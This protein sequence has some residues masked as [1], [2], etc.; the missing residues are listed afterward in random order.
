S[1]GQD[2]SGYGVYAQRYDASGNPVGAEFR[3]NTFATGNQEES[4][5]TSL[6]DGGFVVQWMS[7]G[8]D[9]SGWGTYAQRYDASGNPLSS[10][11]LVNQ[12]TTGDQ[13]PDSFHG[14]TAI[15]QLANGNLISVW[16]GLPSPNNTFEIHA[17]EF[18]LGNPGAV[19]GVRA[20]AGDPTTAVTNGVDA[21]I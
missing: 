20:E 1:N 17:R 4:S 7:L 6:A 18:T 15:A 21:A 14:M 12:T 8:Q 2:G 11:F 5:I 3:V 9:G 10:E 19:I 16:E 13:L